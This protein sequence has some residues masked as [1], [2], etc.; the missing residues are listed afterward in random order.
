[1]NPPN[2]EFLLQI[3]DWQQRLFGYLVTLLGN[4]HDAHD[5]LQETNLVLWRK[6]EEFQEGTDFGAWA[7]KVAWYQA[8]AHLRDKKR[9]RHVFDDDV[10]EMIAEEEPENA[11][12]EERELALR[13]CLAQ[14]PE[15][16]RKVIRCRYHDGDSVKKLAKDLGRKESAMKMMLMRIRQ[17]LMGCIESKLKEELA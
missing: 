14:L 6:M 4:V 1:M 7:R 13:D 15:K 8:L 5:V 11:G 16:Q 17:A 12:E 10:L 3:T 9:D 2:S